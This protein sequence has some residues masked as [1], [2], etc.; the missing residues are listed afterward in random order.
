MALLLSA[1]RITRPNACAAHL[2]RNIE[3]NAAFLPM[4]EDTCEAQ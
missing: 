2:F 4:L 3:P 1:K